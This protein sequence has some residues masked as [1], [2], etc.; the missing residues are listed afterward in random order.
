M[1]RETHPHHSHIWR[2]FRAGG[3]DQV[4]LDN[5][6]DAA[7]LPELDQKLWVAL[8][9]PTRGTEF[10]ER[11]LDLIDTDHDGRIRAPDILAA[12]RWTEERL[13]SIDDLVHATGTMPLAAI[14]ADR[15]EGQEIL[16]SAET[17]LR[18]LGRGGASEIS[19]QDTLDVE[20][21]YDGTPFNG[22]G[23]IPLDAA[24]DEET[25]GALA[26]IIERIGPETDR[27]G[28]PGVSQA[29]ADRF[30]AEAQLY[31]AWHAETEADPAILPLGAAS[32][33][34][35]AAL[36]AVSDKLDDYFTRCRLARYDPRATDA[37]NPPIEAF[38]ALAEQSLALEHPEIAALP[39]ALVEADRPLP[40]EES[41]NPAW[42][43][44]IA[45]FRD[46]AVTP[47]LG[48]R[49]ALGEADWLA[50]K[51]RF[52]AFRAWMAR[53]PATIVEALGIER[54]VGLADSDV[55]ARI[56]A[57]IA[58]DK[59]LEPQ[60]NAIS[61]V[62]KLTRLRRDLLPL[63]NN[64]VSFR[65]FYTRRGKGAFQAG[66][67]YLDGRSC[68]L[69]VRVEDENK[70]AQLAA[71]SRIYLAYCRCTRPGQSA[72]MTIAAAFTAGDSDNLMVGR[73]GVFYDRK[74]ADWDATI[75]K[76]IENPISIR[77][78]FWLPYQQ[79][80]R[81]VGEGVQKLAAARQQAT[82][83]QMIRTVAQGGSAA[84]PAPG[85]AAAAPATQNQAF[86][87][88]KFAGIFAA[89]GLAIGAIG[90]AIASV[91]TGF[92][93]LSWWQMPLA[94]LGIILLISG[95]SVLIAILKLR[96]RNL[97][98]ILDGCGWAVNTRLRINLPFGR[99]L[100]GMAQLPP[101][102]ER[103]LK[104]PYAEKRRPWALYLVIAVAMAAVV[105][106]WRWGVI[107]QWLAQ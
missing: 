38:A 25:R 86:D 11:T 93:H 26:D 43:P 35:A 87:A 10:D 99:A 15:P 53:K 97:G 27:G 1:T 74:G 96:R 88:A 72:I 42:M 37:L 46:A 14:A 2:F 67:L 52:A 107:D 4:R 49:S 75:V 106:L 41:V 7:A 69:C 91:V 80:G 79:F 23:V 77:Q 29:S 81:M 17:I 90:T 31:V 19:L 95:P 24:E 22:D 85:A 55:K 62:E 21:I 98:P 6:R 76:I 47:L 9:C 45:R 56:D 16:A 44:A 73:N 3:F 40:L 51:A 12:V 71:L 34:A 70:H 57:L 8:A 54:L 39:V 100:T 103:S 20:H 94:I 84:A 104:D 28:R 63:L 92:L 61:R 50:I 64:F 68:D 83:A 32:E 60:M 5:G 102:A 82:Q 78:A 89:I 18:M 58:R 13:A 105:V 33:E 30:F 59:A 48:A 101:H 65:N 36:A 66:T